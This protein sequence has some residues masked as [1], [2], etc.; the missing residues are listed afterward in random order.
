LG[1]AFVNDK[2]LMDGDLDCVILE[3]EVESIDGDVNDRED[4]GENEL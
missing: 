1:D 3:V 2:E 4:E